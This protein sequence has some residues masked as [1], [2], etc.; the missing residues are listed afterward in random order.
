MSGW[1]L[2]EVWTLDRLSAAHDF[3]DDNVKSFANAETLTSDFTDF[4]SVFAKLAPYYL[5]PEQP[6]K[7][8]YS[9]KLCGPDFYVDEIGK[10]GST[11]SL[12]SSCLTA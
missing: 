8:A 1:D 5:G 6:H 12:L 4:S 3:F 10:E 11:C 2:D 9:A 7:F